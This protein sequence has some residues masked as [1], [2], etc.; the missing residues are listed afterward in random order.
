MPPFLSIQYK[1]QDQEPITGF[2]FFFGNLVS[3]TVTRPSSESYKI[4][5]THVRIFLQVFFFI[6]LEHCRVLVIYI[7][8]IVFF[9]QKLHIFFAMVNE[10]LLLNS[11][12]KHKHTHLLIICIY[13]SCAQ[14]CSHASY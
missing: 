9:S 7:I 6:L 12:F 5:P 1:N 11:I 14:C 10:S 2:F 8:H 3:C 4:I 13:N